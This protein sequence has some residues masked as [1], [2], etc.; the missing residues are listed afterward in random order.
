MSEREVK[1]SL[2]DLYMKNIWTVKLIVVD[3][4]LCAN[5]VWRLADR[6]IHQLW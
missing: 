4:V 5:I 3:I 2:F 6:F 1:M